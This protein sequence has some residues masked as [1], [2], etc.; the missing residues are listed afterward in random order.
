MTV[1][2][3]MCY[4]GYKGQECGIWWYG[5][6]YAAGKDDLGQLADRHVGNDYF[7]STP[8][9][10]GGLF[11]THILEVVA[12]GGGSFTLFRTTSGSTL[13]VGLNTN[14][15]LGDG[16]IVS[17]DLPVKTLIPANVVI[18]N[19]C[20]ATVHVIAVDTVSVYSCY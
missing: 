17:K 14:G 4:K 7:E 9:Y 10:P 19:M 20:A 11:N 15:Q 1:D 8:I 18:R 6:A 16:T 3:C 12:G 2:T 5:F 13:G